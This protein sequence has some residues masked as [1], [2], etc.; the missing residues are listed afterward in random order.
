[1][2]SSPHPTFVMS[3]QKHQ[4]ISAEFYGL[5]TG[6]FLRASHITK[7]AGKYIQYYSTVLYERQQL[8]P[9]F[10]VPT[11]TLHTPHSRHYFVVQHSTYTQ[12]TSSRSNIP[13]PIHYR[14]RD[15][16]RR[17]VDH[18][19]PSRS[20]FTA[21]SGWLFLTRRAVGCAGQARGA[22]P[23]DTFRRAGSWSAG[24]K[25]ELLWK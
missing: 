22:A 4:S 15:K 25:G 24:R 23:P 16:S 2:T 5:R 14:H 12:Y 11:H 7:N 13:A 20:R 18:A 10:L 9:S 17:H 8:L 1:M 21:T 6:L 19:I 3:C